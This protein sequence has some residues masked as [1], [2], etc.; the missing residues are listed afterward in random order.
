MDLLVKIITFPFRV[1]YYLITHIKLLILAGMACLAVFTFVQCQK[2]SKPVTTSTQIPAQSYQVNAPSKKTCPVVVQTSSRVYYVSDY[3]DKGGLVTLL[4]YYIY[5]KK[6]VL[7]KAPL[8]L[9]P[10]IYGKVAVYER[11]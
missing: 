10:A 4:K 11:K 8:T 5:D 1:L 3:T 6:W 2:P 7:S 9:D